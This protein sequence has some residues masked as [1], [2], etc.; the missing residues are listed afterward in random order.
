MWLLHDVP[1][2]RKLTLVILLTSCAA[3]FVTA[4]ALFAFQIITFRQSFTR[5]L[6]A[7]GEIIANHSTAAVAFKDKVTAKEM[8]EVLQ[9]KPYIVHAQIRLSDGSVFAS[10]GQKVEVPAGQP[11]RTNQPIWFA[12]GHVTFRKALVLDGDEIGLLVLQSDYNQELL[13]LLRLHFGVLGLVLTFSILLTYLLSARLQRVISVPILN[14]AETA[15]VVAEHKDYGVRAEVRERDE[16]GQ[17]TEAFNQML[18]Q[19]QAQDAALRVS[20]QKFETLVHSIDGI[21]WEADPSDLHFYFVSQQAERL[22]GYSAP[23]WL[24]QPRFW[25]ERLHPDDRQTVLSRLRQGISQ[26][27]PFALEFR[28]MAR[29]GRELWV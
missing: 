7:L 21:V 22:L 5:D 27:K 3:I 19:I 1:I 4:A 25:E 18:G 6:A 16:I 9:V 11:S 8:L 10:Y 24:E 28:L 14:L 26:L 23:Q 13:R 29:D 2:K 15:R 12:D 20:Q 17:F